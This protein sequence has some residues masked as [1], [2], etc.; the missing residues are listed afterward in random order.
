MSEPFIG[1][2]ELYGFNFVPENWS[3]CQGQLIGVAAEQAMFS[4][5]GN[6]Y[7]GDGRTNFALP[8]LRGRLAMSY[9]NGIG[10]Q[11]HY[12]IGQQAGSESQ[13]LDLTELASHTHHALFTPNPGSLQIEL[14]ATTDGGDNPSPSDGAYLATTTVQSG[15]PDKPELIYRSE[16]PSSGSKVSLGGPIAAT[17]HYEGNVTVG[18]TGNSVPFSIM[19]PSLVMN[20]SIAMR[21]LY[22]SRS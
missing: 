21:G 4:L 14:S 18:D 2:V 12:N 10:S 13:T 3:S 11:Y 22:P 17:T 7:G 20:Y 9:G 1:Q 16:A 5:L 19:H 6:A 15:G 8:D